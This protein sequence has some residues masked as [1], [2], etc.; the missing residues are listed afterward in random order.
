MRIRATAIVPPVAMADVPAL[1]AKAK[2]TGLVQL[3]DGLLFGAKIKKRL[4]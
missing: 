1:I 2:G 3:S 4:T